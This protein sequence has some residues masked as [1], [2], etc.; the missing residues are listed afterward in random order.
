MPYLCNSFTPQ[1]GD[2]SFL[3]DSGPGIKATLKLLQISY[4]NTF[5]EQ[6]R[7]F[8]CDSYQENISNKQAMHGITP[9]QGRR[10]YHTCSTVTRDSFSINRAAR[11]SP[12]LILQNI[13]FA[14]QMCRRRHRTFCAMPAFQATQEK[15][16]TQNKHTTKVHWLPSH[17]I[18][19]GNKQQ[20]CGKY[21]KGVGPTAL[22]F[23][24]EQALQSSRHLHPPLPPV[25]GTLTGLS[26]SV[27]RL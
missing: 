21:K 1:I 3:D 13:S 12:H 4:R 18:A 5:Y 27:R 20:Q 17:R 26:D 14:P 10:Q 11:A 22:V 16:T 23:P 24:R 8:G 2:Y 15:V 19:P 6:S 9:G 7:P 25:R